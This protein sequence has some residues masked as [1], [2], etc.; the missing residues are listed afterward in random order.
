[1][2]ALSAALEV[3]QSVSEV[4]TIHAAGTQHD[5]LLSVTLSHGVLALEVKR[6]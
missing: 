6:C 1:M 4:V 5:L 3:V 2:W